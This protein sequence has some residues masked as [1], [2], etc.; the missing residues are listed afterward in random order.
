MRRQLLT[1]LA[2]VAVAAGGVLFFR[3]RAAAP[4]ASNAEYVDPALCAGCHANIWETYR[5]T[6]MAR[7][8]YR[9]SPETIKPATFYHNLS[10]S[11]FTI[12][13]RNG[14][15]Y[16]RRYQ[17][18]FDGKETNQVEKQIDYVVGSGNHVRAYLHRTSR[19][20]LTELPLAW[21]AEKGGSPGMNPG[22]D[23]AD[24]AGFARAITDSCMFC[25]NGIPETAWRGNDAKGEAT[26]PEPVPQGIDCQRC[27]GPGSRHVDMAVNG[28]KPEDIRRAIVNPAH[29]S[30]DRRIEVCMQCHLETTS[31]RLPN[32]ILRYG[33]ER[34]SFRPGEPLS[35]YVLQFDHSAGTG[36]DDKF[37]IVGAAY[38]LRRSACFQKSAG[39]LDCT[40]CHNPHDIPRGEEGAR[41]YTA[42]CRQCHD[43]AVRELSAAGRHPQSEDCI[44]CHM[45]KRRTDDVVHAVMT[46]HYIQRRKPERDLL[47]LL[48]EKRDTAEN[49]YR[50][51]V[52]L[53]YPRELPDARDRELYWAVAQVSQQSNLG[54]G[55]PALAAAIDKYRPERAEYYLHLADA[56]SNSGQPEKAIPF[57]E[58]AVR[59]EPDSLIALRQLGFSLRLSG[60]PGRAID[61]FKRALAVAPSD[62]TTWHE[63]GLAYAAQRSKDDA[64]AAFQKA[65]ELDEDI[66]EPY[67]SLGA[68][69][70][71]NKDLAHAE[72]AFREAIRRQPDYA[73]AHSNLG[74]VLSA[75]G[76]FEEARYHFETAI[77][78]RPDYGA[79]RYNYALA[80]AR[81]RRFD[82]ARRQ[83]EAELKLDP[84]A[85]EA[86]DLL[87]NL[88]AAQGKIEPAV[89]EYQEAIKVRPEYA[90][91]QLDLGELLAESGDVIGALPHLE[92]AAASSEPAVSAE[93][94]Q[95]L[96]QLGNK[97]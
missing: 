78:Q 39:A 24:H 51:E 86:H 10:D 74:N 97:R 58:A 8:F 40:T 50:G 22:Y 29:L 68:V 56:W 13:E 11:Y 33:R 79:A 66:A 92:K 85:A 73:E 32:A 95:M 19:G 94:R 82:E 57:Y 91:A 7:S 88:L 21:Y 89:Q 46:D 16:Q 2:G 30:P 84:G 61:V 65:G 5:R 44:G 3:H 64:I 83:L 96:G 26:F 38:R 9:P 35:D 59:H 62:A 54:Q 4:V 53:Y 15:F 37:E 52:V 42:V 47:A 49:G 28:A 41:H 36:H 31:T 75:S 17:I 43:A 77:R 69:W 80:L 18:G 63:L 20:T 14:R 67:N 76:R 70:L 34:F 81:V 23:R 93:A 55:I 48:E 6:G 71:E 25:H 72:P 45:P 87:G 60:Q 27:H 1:V 12:T 90:R